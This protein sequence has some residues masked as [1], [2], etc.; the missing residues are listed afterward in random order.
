MTEEKYGDSYG[1]KFRQYEDK[2]KE[3]EKENAELKKNYEDSLIV[4][5]VLKAKIDTLT[6]P[7]PLE[8]MQDVLITTQKV[9]YEKQREQLTEAK[10]IIKLLLWDLRN[11]SYEP[12]KDLERAEQFIK[13][14]E[15]G[16]C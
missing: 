2:I 16:K 4:C 5:G 11:R 14:S 6:Q 8:S 9:A 15:V 12:V 13:D 10:E 7:S 3:L 1:E